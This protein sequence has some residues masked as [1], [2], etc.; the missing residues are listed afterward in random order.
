MSEGNTHSNNTANSHFDNSLRPGFPCD[1]TFVRG[2][3]RVFEGAGR[4]NR[5]VWRQARRT[6]CVCV[7]DL[8]ERSVSASFPAAV[9]VLPVTKP[10]AVSTDS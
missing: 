3:L 6:D 8:E 7:V 9:V 1:R 4:H 10:P 2:E 5:R